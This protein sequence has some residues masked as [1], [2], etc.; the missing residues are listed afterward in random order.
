[1]KPL[2]LHCKARKGN[3]TARNAALLPGFDGGKVYT[4]FEA[5]GNVDR[6]FK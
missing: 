5:Q 4:L 6:H 3:K 2:S 1:M